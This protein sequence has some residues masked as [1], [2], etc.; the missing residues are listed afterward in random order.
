MRSVL[1]KLAKVLTVFALALLALVSVTGAD[2][3]SAAS[4]MT[5]AKAQKLLK[6]EIKN[7]FCR[8]TFADVDGDGISEMFVLGYSTKF[9]DGDAKEKTLTVYKIEDGKVKSIFT[10]GIDGDFYHPSLTFNLYYDGECYITVNYEH[11]GFAYYTTYMYGADSFNEIAFIEVDIAG[12]E[13]TYY[14]RNKGGMMP[15]TE[16]KYKKFMKNILV[17]EVQV[18]LL[19]PSVKVANKYFK[20]LLKAEFNFRCKHGVFDK[21]TVRLVYSDENGDGIDE[22]IVNEN[23]ISGVVLYVEE[24]NDVIKD[25][26]VS[27]TSYTL[28]D[29]KI[30]FGD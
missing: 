21:N 5:N 29:G 24:P 1:N 18:E 10:D 20:K 22:L 6:K 3:V 27:S 28:T 25:Y 26:H 7:K 2:G 14:I 8:Y 16:K 13:Y 19:T 12:N 4:K 30:V 15:C 9:V 23:A 11:E 17:G